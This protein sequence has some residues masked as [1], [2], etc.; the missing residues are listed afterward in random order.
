LVA[1]VIVAFDDTQLRS[2]PSTVKL[3]VTCTLGDMSS[4]FMVHAFL[5]S[6][7]EE[8]SGPTDAT[9]LISAVESSGYETVKSA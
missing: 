8:N 3:F 9:P 1:V 4:A 5:R 2:L 7:A 6:A